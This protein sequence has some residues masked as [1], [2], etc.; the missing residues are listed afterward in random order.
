MK[1]REKNAIIS[2]YDVKELDYFNQGEKN[3]NREESFAQINEHTIIYMGDEYRI[4]KEISV[5]TP[6]IGI[7]GKKCVFKFEFDTNLEQYNLVTDIEP[8]VECSVFALSI[9]EYE[10][11]EMLDTSTRTTTFTKYPTDENPV[12]ETHI[13]AINNETGEHEKFLVALDKSEKAQKRFRDIDTW[14]YDMMERYEETIE[15]IDVVKYLLYFL[16]TK[17]TPVLNEC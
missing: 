4:P 5:T 16:Q 10:K 2:V 11:I 9:D 13:Y 1:T 8:L 14:L 6:I 12:V 7:E 17:K 15:L 3:E